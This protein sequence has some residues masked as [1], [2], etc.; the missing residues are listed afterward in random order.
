[1]SEPFELPAEGGDV[2]R[3]FV[4]PVPLNESRYVE[5]LEFLPAERRLVHHATIT[6]DP[7]RSSRRLDARDP[8]PGFDG[9][10]AA[11]GA[12]MPDGHFLGWTS[13][14]SPYREPKGM[15][16]RLERQS[17]LVVQLHMPT[18]GKPE[19]VHASVGLF[20]TDDAP[21]LVPVTLRLG[22]RHFEIPAG[23]TNYKVE[24]VYVLPVDVEAMSIYPH[25]H[26]L[27]WEMKAKA[28]LPDGSEEWLLYIPEW[29]FNW[30]D[31]YRYREPVFLPKG[32]RL[33]M[34]YSYDNSESNPRNPHRPPKHVT[35]GPQSTDEM[36]D[37][38]IQVLPARADELD[39][40]RSDY[41]AKELNERV[42]E[43][44]FRIERNPEDAEALNALGFTYDAL[45]R[46]DDAVQ[47]IREAVRIAPDL[48][49]GHFNL[50][51]LLAA[52][53]ARAEAIGHFENVLR[54]DPDCLDCRV[55]LGNVL[56]EVGKLNEA[57]AELEKAT[58]LDPK[59]AWAHYSLGIA[60][61]LRGRLAEA[62]S[63]YRK[64]VRLDPKDVD[65]RLSLGSA[66]TAAGQ[67]AQAVLELEQAVR[68]A[69]QPQ[70]HEPLSRLA[71]ALTTCPN[72]SPDALER[73]VSAAQ[74]A[75]E[76]TSY[77]DP[78][79]LDTLA[80]AL[81]AS[82]K[83]TEARGTWERALE[84]AQRSGDARFASELQ[85]KLSRR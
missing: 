40:L 66:L 21:R 18:T 45:G 24:D 11:P 64:V 48:E 44:T 73:A 37:L 82:G 59:H 19:R 30:Q 65:A 49:D 17:D 56:R 76:L 70:W 6:I 23:T 58:E 31:F 46:S 1:M 63:Q 47:T 51:T 53:G 42:A 10:R 15:S 36:G 25:A 57:V 3:N 85:R 60:L 55:R 77:R 7:T 78:Y 2:F 41:A 69:R 84:L 20:F 52:R 4:V 39:V 34:E 32:T 5:A 8:G 75:A 68:L 74:Q 50:G 35:Y 81:A 27:A 61:Q 14:K 28:I 54:S 83:E 9:M 79:V 13:G 67:C 12:V 71:W 16:W 29:D 80:A 62:I 43:L 22:S 38:Y 33:T 26:Y 72:D